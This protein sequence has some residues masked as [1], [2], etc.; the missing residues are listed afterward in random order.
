LVHP[1]PTNI[2]ERLTQAIRLVEV[3]EADLLGVDLLLRE[4]NYLKQDLV[5][6]IAYLAWEE[7]LCAA[8]AAP[9]GWTGQ[10]MSQVLGVV[11]LFPQKN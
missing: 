5:A 11:H 7:G 1:P 10:P 4:V 8:L 9:Q 6:P 2:P 3:E